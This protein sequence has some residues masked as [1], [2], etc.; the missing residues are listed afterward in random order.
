MNGRRA[1]AHR[2]A[3]WA[4]KGWE[5]ERERERERLSLSPAHELR[6]TI[7][8]VLLET[9][10]TIWRRLSPVSDERFAEVPLGLLLPPEDLL[11]YIV[12]NKSSG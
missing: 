5:R 9:L 1:L 7:L 10:A 3:R 4:G 12:N 11:C 8:T 6:I 2:V